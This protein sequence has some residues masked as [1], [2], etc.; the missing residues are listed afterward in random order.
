MYCINLSIGIGLIHF[1]ESYK[2]YACHKSSV[3][4]DGIWKHLLHAALRDVVTCPHLEAKVAEKCSLP[5]FS[6]EGMKLFGECIVLSITIV[7]N[8]FDPHIFGPSLHIL[9]CVQTSVL[10]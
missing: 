8:L 4:T 2:N 5:T 7:L 1:F 3:I 6:R 10:W 9:F